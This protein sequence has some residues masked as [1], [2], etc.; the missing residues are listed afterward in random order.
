MESHSI[1]VLVTGS[2]GQLG[3]EIKTISAHYPTLGLTF[4]DIDELD[5]TN[6][7]AVNDF[8]K[9]LNPS[10]VVNCAA[11]TA[12]D[13]AEQEPE[14]ANRINSLAPAIIAAACKYNGCKMIHISTDYVFD[15]ESK[16]P[17]DESSPVNPV[18]QEGCSNIRY[19]YGYKDILALLILWK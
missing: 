5:I 7:I 2:K 16:T 13:K 8:I 9:T 4:T 18:S 15:G 19:L 1:K 14:A 17:Y 11:Y 6:P 12:V 10:F 3:S